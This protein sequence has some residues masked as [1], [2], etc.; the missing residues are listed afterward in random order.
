MVREGPSVAYLTAFLAAVVCVPTGY[1]DTSKAAPPARPQVQERGV[2]SL[3]EEAPVT[4]WKPGDPVRVVPDL[5]EDGENP[6]SEGQP[7]PQPLK[8]V[9][10]TPVVPQVTE[11]SVN[12]LSKA[13]PYREGNPVRVVPDLRESD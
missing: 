1:A 11:R 12:E 10:R 5:R 4:K 3:S 2:D 7:P 6:V 9:V 8:P 13:E